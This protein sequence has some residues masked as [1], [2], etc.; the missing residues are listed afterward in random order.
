M[1]LQTIIKLLSCLA[2]VSC[3]HVPNGEIFES[4]NDDG[5]QINDMVTDDEKKYVEIVGKY[6]GD[7]Q[8]TYSG[9]IYVPQ[10]I[11][12]K[13]EDYTVVAVGPRAFAYSEKLR[14]V[15]L[16]STVTEIKDEGFYNCNRLETIKMPQNL[17]AIG[18]FA[19]NH[20]QAIDTLFIP[21][22]IRKIGNGA[23]IDA[24]S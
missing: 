2:I 4:I 5:I 8:N 23:F 11:S 12:Y 14:A 16:P 3:T 19:F 9:T 20:C 1:K 13:G 7:Y 15:I 24:S 22:S 6:V 17:E 10:S 18:R 21:K